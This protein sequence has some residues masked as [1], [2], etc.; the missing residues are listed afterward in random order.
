MA[1]YPLSYQIYTP[2]Q[3]V[4]VGVTVGTGLLYTTKEAIPAIA[5]YPGKVV[6]DKDTDILYV[7]N[8]SLAF[9]QLPLTGAQL[10][11]VLE[12]LT[13]PNRLNKSA[14]RGADFSLNRRG[15]GDIL[16]P[17][18]STSMI[19]IL[20]GDFWIYYA[21]GAGGSDYISEGDWV[22][23]MRDGIEYTF[24][25]Q[26]EADWQIVHFGDTGVTQQTI[27]LKHIRISPT[28]G[29]SP[30]LTIPNV[31]AQIV[32]IGMNHLVYYGKADDGQFGEYDF[33]YSISGNDTVITL[34]TGMLDFSFST[35]MQVDI[36]YILNT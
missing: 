13:G 5:K 18:Y 35:G 21:G 16:D 11:S 10:V 31:H 2:N 24:N 22:I 29:E 8:S 23:A 3:S 26:N 25:F 6:Y 34:N 12:A 7:V 1:I 28:G 27:E 15:K 20:R 30:S 33:V 17:S 4:E 9:V 32:S 14:V 19:N 36:T